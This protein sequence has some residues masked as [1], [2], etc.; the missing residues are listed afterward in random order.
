MSQACYWLL[1]IIHAV[2]EKALEYTFKGFIFGGLG[3]IRARY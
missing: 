1:C 3:E 2:K